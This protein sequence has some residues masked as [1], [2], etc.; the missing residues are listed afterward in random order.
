MQATS[1]PGLAPLGHSPLT[2]AFLLPGAIQGWIDQRIQFTLETDQ[3]P[4]PA[5][6]TTGKV[7]EC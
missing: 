5:P 3:L 1:P 4:Q 6:V 7:K 2:N